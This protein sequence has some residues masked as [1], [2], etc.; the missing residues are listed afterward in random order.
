MWV[1]SQP[2]DRPPMIRIPDFINKTT[3]EELLAQFMKVRFLAEP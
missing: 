2:A 3:A 1:L